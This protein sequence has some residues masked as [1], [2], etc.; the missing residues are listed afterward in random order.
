[1][2]AWR[3][4]LCWRCRALAQGAGGG[5]GG[6]WDLGVEN[7]GMSAHCSFVSQVALWVAW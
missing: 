2:E 5:G 6:G 1:M 3:G 4:A 7:K